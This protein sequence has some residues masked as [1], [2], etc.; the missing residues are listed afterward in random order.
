MDSATTPMAPSGDRTGRRRASAILRRRPQNGHGPL[1]AGHAALASARP[2]LREDLV[3]ETDLAGWPCR[4]VT[5]WGLFSPREI[6]AGTRMLIGCLEP[7]PDDDCLDLGC[8]YGPIG[9]F[10]AH[11]AQGGR[12][13][14]VDRD[15][16][17]VAYAV[18]NAAAN[19]L[20]NA[21]ARLS[22]GL[23]QLDGQTFDLIASNLP[24]KV[25][26]ELYTILLEDAWAHLR[27]G[28]RFQAVFIRHLWPTLRREAQRVFGN[29]EKLREGSAYVVMAARREDR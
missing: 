27:S 28:G 2:D 16:V 22:N 1:S 12:T 14:M 15:F 26:R 23:A 13:L 24:A 17:A 8:G 9:C 5:T 20:T 4:F 21:S 19:G 3:I 18:R 25:G 10:M 29:V 6:D 11:K 7:R